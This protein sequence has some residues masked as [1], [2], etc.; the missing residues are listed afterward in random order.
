MYMEREHCMLV[1]LQM[2]GRS[3]E[4]PSSGV[5]SEVSLEWA[6][7]AERMPSPERMKIFAEST[8]N[9]L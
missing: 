7:S 6:P 2:I 5:P 8:V 3:S 4:V 1:E 9:T